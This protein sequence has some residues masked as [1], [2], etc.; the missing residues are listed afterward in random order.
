MAKIAQEFTVSFPRGFFT[1]H[2]CS[3]PVRQVTLWG[4]RRT[5]RGTEPLPAAARRGQQLE[6]LAQESSAPRQSFCIESFSFM[7]TVRLRNS[8]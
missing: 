1:P 8:L 4:F 6:S 2:V 5:S 7:F 3:S